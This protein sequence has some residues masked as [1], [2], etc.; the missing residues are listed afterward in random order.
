M[1]NPT[2]LSEAEIAELETWL[3]AGDRVGV[4]VQFRGHQ[5]ARLVATIRALQSDVKARDAAI[6]YLAG[7]CEQVHDLQDQV[8]TGWSDWHPARTALQVM[9][10][11]VART[12]DGERQ[13][14]QC[15]VVDYDCTMAGNYRPLKSA[16]MGDYWLCKECCEKP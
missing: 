3:T 11:D 16:G 8:R 1:S 5:T 13:C 15:S 7:E 9:G 4:A 12:Q 10:K 6:K 14:D 2:P